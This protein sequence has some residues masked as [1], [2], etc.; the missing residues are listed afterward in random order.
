MTIDKHYINEAKR[1]RKVYLT[2]LACIV[3]K[4]DE[5]QVYFNMIE[6][7]RK[8]IKDSEETKDE[9]FINK[10]YEINDHI[11]KIK[12]YIIPHYDKIKELDT[13]Q[14]ILY[15]NIKE[16]YTD[17]TNDE[18]QE[19]IVPHIIPV[20][21]IFIKKNQELYNKIKEKENKF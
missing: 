20:D 13:S 10:L 16:K 15:N 2:N 11:E 8:E 19:Q 17:I 4:E 9:Y 3:E 1:I 12:S 14:R 18:I 7:I 6:D 5:I 21:Q